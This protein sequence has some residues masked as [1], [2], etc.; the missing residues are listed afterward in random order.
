MPKLPQISG[1]DCV[2]ALEKIGFRFLR[3]T[4]SHLHMRRDDPFKQ[5]AVP[6]HKVLKKGL[7]RSVIRDADLTVEE[8]IELL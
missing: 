7:L 2:K 8:F 4:G 3:Q 6:N 5:I 1:R